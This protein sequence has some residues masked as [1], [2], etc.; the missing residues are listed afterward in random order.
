MKR[1]PGSRGIV[2]VLGML[3][4]IPVA[5]IACLTMPY[6]VGLERLGYDV[7]YLEEHGSNPSTFMEHD[8]GARSAAAYLNAVMQSFGFGDR[9]CFH[10]LHSDGSYHGMSEHRVN[11]V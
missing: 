3:T 2:V 10:A 9:W 7:Y 4:R 6:L 1:R 11:E 5:G 8:D